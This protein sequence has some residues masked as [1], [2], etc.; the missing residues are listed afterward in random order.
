MKKLLSIL[1]VVLLAMVMVVS[2]VGAKGKDRDKFDD[3]DKREWALK[4]VE[5]AT[6]KY[7]DVNKAIR[8][9]YAPAGPYVGGMGFHY[10]TE[11]VLSGNVD[12]NVDALKPEILVYAPG[13]NGE[14][15]LVAVEYVST[16]PNSLFGRTFDGPHGIPWHSL[17]AWIY[18]H[19]PAGILTGMN[20]RIPATLEE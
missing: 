11:E 5:K 16:N 12:A 15:Q 2:V 6:E 17:H 19:N 4:K 1:L 9:G 14:L 18:K 13:K 10:G 20:P 7:K 3:R 8:D